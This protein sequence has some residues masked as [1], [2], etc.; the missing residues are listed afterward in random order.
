MRPPCTASAEP[1]DR[2]IGRRPKL[3]SRGEEACHRGDGGRWRDGVDQERFFLAAVS[4]EFGA[5]RQALA[6]TLRV[7]GNEVREQ[8]D[9]GADPRGATLPDKLHAYVRTRSRSFD[10][11]S[12]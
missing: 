1:G 9:I 3:V 12:P 4:R 7:P 8:S 11:R 2:G 10:G 6:R 5:A